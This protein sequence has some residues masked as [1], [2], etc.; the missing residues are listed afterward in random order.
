MSTLDKKANGASQP[1][2]R[3]VMVV[4][5]DTVVCTALTALLQARGYNVT[6]RSQALGTSLAIMRDKPDIVVLD[7]DMPG[8]TGDA[9]SKILLNN[10]PAPAVIFYSSRPTEE[11][12]RIV[13]ETRALGAIR[14]GDPRE[15]L[16]PFE[17]LLARQS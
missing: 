5:D 16:L 14:K 10:K 8:L 17:T 2:R 6:C 4:D 12:E 9:I 15:F 11:L 3:K 1:T 7:V 13:N